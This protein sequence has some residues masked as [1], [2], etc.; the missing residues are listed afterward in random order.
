[1]SIAGL[2]KT[3]G[4]RRPLVVSLG[5]AVSLAVRVEPQLVRRA[6]LE[7]VP[8]ADASTE[9]DLWFS[10]LVDVG[11]TTA[12]MLLPEVAAEFRRRLATNRDRLE[13]A[14]TVTREVHRNTAPAIALEE[15]VNYLALAEGP[16]SAR[17]QE[18][19]QRAVVALVEGGDDRTGVARWALRALPRLAPSVAESEAGLM[20]TVAARSRLGHA[21]VLPEGVT[22]DTKW[23][24][25][26][27]P[28]ESERVNIGVRLYEQ[29]L[30][31]GGPDSS[32]GHVI[33]LP[34]TDPLMLTVS[35][36][37]HGEE[38]RHE[39]PVSPDRELAIHVKL[40][41]VQPPGTEEVQR[42]A[43]PAFTLQT[44]WGDTYT[45][46]PRE[47]EPRVPI[48]IR[49]IPSGRGVFLAWRPA[50]RIDGCLGFALHRRRSDGREEVVGNP[51]AFTEPTKGSP[52]GREPS[53]T[54]PFQRFTWLEQDVPG[55]GTAQYRVVPMLGSPAT[56]TEGTP[57]EWSDPISIPATTEP[58]LAATFNRGVLGLDAFLARS[59]GRPRPL[60]EEIR[61]PGS[62][63]REWLG[64]DLLTGLLG[65]LADTATAGGSLYAALYDLDDPEVLTHLGALG[66]RAR[67]LLGAQRGP[68]PQVLELL[69][70]RGVGVTPVKPRSGG[71]FHHRFAVACDA[72]GEPT[73][74][75]IGGAGWTTTALCVHANSATIVD[76]RE[77]AAIFQDL[78]Q[79][80]YASGGRMKPRERPD[81]ATVGSARV[82]VW[83]TPAVKGLDLGEVRSRVRSA[84]RGVLFTL[85]FA[86]RAPGLV[87]NLFEGLPAYVQGIATGQLRDITLM[88]DGK[89]TRVPRT[90]YL[91]A[92]RGAD[93]ELHAR[94]V[95]ID[96]FDR[97]PIVLVGSHNL[98][99]TSS[100]RSN[101]TLIMVENAPAFAAAHAVRVTA[102]YQYYAPQT[103]VQEP[104]TFVR[105]PPDRPVLQAHDA[106]QDPY[107]TSERQ[108]ELALW[109]D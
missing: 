69:P 22:P 78:W 33:P 53:T 6:R 37:E 93:N 23:L 57:S 46:R 79:E 95:V 34:K 66:P 39:V 73:R 13:H 86:D 68:S 109:L 20:L 54:A 35:W 36:H 27:L 74:V 70:S 26:V 4:A 103:T 92:T 65:F 104:A 14:W 15:E 98:T 45:I 42:A 77:L 38:L 31:I 62:D 106:W 56:L 29:G 99:R 7:L 2:I 58:G 67:L 100:E 55:S 3:V 25:W 102:L 90:S 80:L 64:G 48:V 17:L 60:G 91:D 89:P 24:P 47:Q 18:R 94:A 59:G 52:G 87:K 63:Y 108:R 51:R 101:E 72:D 49:A 81:A 75:W 82:G 97:G 30:E 84:R 19:L 88:R 61:S 1:V 76:S 43:P 21:D 16:E 85:P 83:F 41:Y 28:R 8:E 71:I 105:P 32:S 96:P 10:A 40:P 11:S 5:E 9:A 12:F 44:A 107:F 50:R